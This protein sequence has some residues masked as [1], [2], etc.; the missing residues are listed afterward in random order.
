[1]RF[2]HVNIVARD[3]RA[4]ARFYCDVFDCVVVPPERKLASAW[5]DRIVGL[6]NAVVEG[7]HLRLPGHGVVGPTLEIFTYGE[8]ISG[9]TSAANR[10]GFAHIAFEVESAATALVRAL[11]HGGQRLGEIVTRDLAGVGRR[12]VV[13]CR[14]PEGNIVEIQ[15]PGED[16]E[17]LGP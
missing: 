11:A 6:D 15:A 10:V 4:L 3:W 17:A 12:D 16:G 8:T 2:L 13:Y 14:D 7:V 5:L 1:M 9:G